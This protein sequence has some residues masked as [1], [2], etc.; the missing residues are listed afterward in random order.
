MDQGWQPGMA[1]A[2]DLAAGAA[3][4]E[5]LAAE[6]DSQ[7]YAVSLITGEG[8]RPGLHITNRC[9]MQLAEYV[10][11]DGEHFYWGWAER[12]GPVADLPA[13]AAAVDRVLQVLGGNR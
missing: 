9:A 6:L 3:E 12:I 13:V 11:S 10:Y 2:Q 8:R 1:N 4:L 5:Q 7:T